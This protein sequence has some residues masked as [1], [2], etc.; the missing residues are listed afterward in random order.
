MWRGALGDAV[1]WI[2]AVVVSLTNSLKLRLSAED[3][4]TRSAVGTQQKVLTGFGGLQ[5]QQQNPSGPEGG[6][7]VLSG[8]LGNVKKGVLGWIGSRC[9]VYMYEIVN[10]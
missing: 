7:R 9:I 3:Q 1:L 10:K 5:K 4:S 2:H 8:C 6:K